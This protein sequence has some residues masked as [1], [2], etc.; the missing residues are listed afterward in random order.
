MAAPAA[1]EVEGLTATIKVLGK[2]DK[3]LRKAAGKVVREYA[4]KIKS[5]AWAKYKTSPGVSRDGYKLT[6]GA[7]SHRAT[8]TKASVGINRQSKVGRNAAIFAAEFGAYTATVPRFDG[9][10]VRGRFRVYGQNDMRRRTF[11]VWRGNNTTVRG[12]RGPGWV[13]MPILRKRVPE[14]EKDLNRDLLVVMQGSLRKAGVK[15]G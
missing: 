8:A 7:V 5:E 2:V 11:P 1:I 6:K 15:R 10:G 12:K 4:V 13:M 9:K 3:D 14:I